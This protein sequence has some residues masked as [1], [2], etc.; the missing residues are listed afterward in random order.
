MQVLRDQSYLAISPSRQKVTLLRNLIKEKHR[1]LAFVQQMTVLE[2][3][4]ALHKPEFNSHRIGLDTNMAA[5]SLFW[6]TI[7]APATSCENAFI[8]DHE[9]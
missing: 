7:M 2:Q 4:K 3:K 1:N 6:D 8:I 5:V 9:N